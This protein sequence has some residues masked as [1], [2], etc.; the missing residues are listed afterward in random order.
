MS[1]EDFN[2]WSLV[3]GVI[4]LVITGLGAL[5]IVVSIRQTR[6]TI[7]QSA[8]QYSYDVWRA[9]YD[10]LG[11]S[12]RIAAL[13][14]AHDVDAADA[15]TLSAF[16]MILDMYADMF[17]GEYGRIQSEASLLRRV[18]RSDLGKKYW[19]TYKDSFFSDKE[20]IREIDRLAEG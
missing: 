12:P 6:S 2:K 9:L 1:P 18:I 10:K 4:N 13:F 14:G 17:A 20:F 3:I 19:A 15:S 7:K 16:L 8:R 5:F 11:Q